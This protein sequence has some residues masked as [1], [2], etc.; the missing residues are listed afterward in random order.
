MVSGSS[1]VY[2]LLYVDDIILTG[3]SEALITEVKQSLQTEFDM[4]DLGRLHYFLGLE[5]QYLTTGLFVSQHKYANDLV[6]K[7]GLDECNSHLTP[8]QSGLKLYAA[9]DDPL[10]TSEVTQFRSLVGCL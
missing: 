9:D 7:V 6:H 10:P 1:R 4:K 2:L 3:D 8:S 5:I